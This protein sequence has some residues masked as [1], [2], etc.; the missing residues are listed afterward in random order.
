[1]PL[2]LAMAPKKRK[3]SQDPLQLSRPDTLLFVGVSGRVRVWGL[4]P[5]RPGV[6]K[7]SFFHLCFCI[8]FFFLCLW[9][10][11]AF[12]HFSFC[13]MF[14]FR[15][16]FSLSVCG[17]CTQEKKKMWVLSKEV[18]NSALSGDGVMGFLMKKRKEKKKM[19][20]W[21]S[22][23]TF[24]DSCSIYTYIHMYVCM[25][26]PIG[27]V[28]YWLFLFFNGRNNGSRGYHAT[29]GEALSYFFLFFLFQR[30][31]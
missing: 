26:I 15:S 6:L 14:L 12:F 11:D 27:N 2:A 8:F 31:T 3:K 24:H 21:F 16:A 5:W 19:R 29:W 1:M 18:Q 13:F 28:R 20:D 17:A 10:I 4:H 9:R 7:F 30:Q 22:P 23:V 25:Y